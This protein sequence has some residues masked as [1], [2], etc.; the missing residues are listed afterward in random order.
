MIDHNSFDAAFPKELQLL[1][2]CAMAD[3]Y[4]EFSAY[5]H[6]FIDLAAQ[7]V[8]QQNHLKFDSGNA[9]DG[10][11]SKIMDNI[12]SA[13]L[14][15]RAAVMSGNSDIVIEQNRN[16]YVVICES[17]ILGSAPGSGSD[18]A[19]DHLFEGVLQ[20]TS[21]Y[22]TGSYGNDHSILLIL[23]FKPQMKIKLE[24]W[25]EYFFAKSKED[26]CQ[27]E[28]DGLVDFCYEEEHLELGL[29]N[30]RGFITT[31]THYSSGDSVHIRHVPVCLHFNPIDKSGRK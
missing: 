12:R 6:Q 27:H 3:S 14:N 13:G 1:F 22:T 26:F 2:K 23:C 20:L 25:K 30:L 24:R 29:K 19:N 18:Y 28:F 15:V 9:E 8:E 4:E 10:W 17:K 11:T 31:H 5:T 21:R 16:R 7:R